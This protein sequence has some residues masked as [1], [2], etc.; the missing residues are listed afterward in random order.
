MSLQLQNFRDLDFHFVTPV[1]VNAGQQLQ[2]VC[3]AGCDG[4]AVYYSGY[5]R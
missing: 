1:V 3:P 2:V 4:A 5:Q